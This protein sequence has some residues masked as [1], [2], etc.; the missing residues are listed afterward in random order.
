MGLL[1]E[2]GSPKPAV[3]AYAEV[4]GEMGL[5]QWFHYQDHR[6]DDAVDWMKRLGVSTCARG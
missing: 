1:R 3:D 5:C 6:L 2:D 4:A